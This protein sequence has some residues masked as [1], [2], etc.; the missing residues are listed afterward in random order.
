MNI[1]AIVTSN[2]T[3]A[4]DASI[5]A[6]NKVEFYV[7]NSKIAEDTVE[8]YE[9]IWDT[10]T[11]ADGSHTIKAVADADNNIVELNETNNERTENISIAYPDLTIFNIT[12][13]P[14]VINYADTITFNATIENNGSG[15]TTRNFKNRLITWNKD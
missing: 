5:L 9:C 3:S 1:K 6:I 13:T 7:D 15:N 11:H 12:W 14:R 10:T 2:L 4:S 8:P